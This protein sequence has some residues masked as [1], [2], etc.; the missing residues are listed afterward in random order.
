MEESGFKCRSVCRPQPSSPRCPE[1]K[2]VKP[3]L[4]LPLSPAS[5]FTSTS[6]LSACPYLRVGTACHTATGAT[7]HC[8]GASSRT[9]CLPIETLQRPTSSSSAGCAIN[10]LHTAET[11]GCLVCAD[12]LGSPLSLFSKRQDRTQTN[13]THPPTPNGP[14]TPPTS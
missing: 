1:L 3:D 2:P 6:T 13:H 7:R 11:E 8:Q 4:S 12:L 9:G 10:L 14:S 5:P